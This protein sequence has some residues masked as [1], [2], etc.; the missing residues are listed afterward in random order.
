MLRDRGND[1]TPKAIDH[2]CRIGR[3]SRIASASKPNWDMVRTCQR[4][5]SLVSVPHV[6]APHLAAERR[7]TR[8][9]LPLSNQNEYT[10]LRVSSESSFF[11]PAGGGGVSSQKASIGVKQ[12]TVENQ[13][14][15]FHSM[16][17]RGGNITG[18]LNDRVDALGHYA[19]SLRSPKKP[20]RY[21]LFKRASIAI[22]DLRTG[23]ESV[24]NI[25]RYLRHGDFL[26]W[27]P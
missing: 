18:I 6:A 16:D 5:G 3:R 11:R 19:A 14:S 20:A 22:N 2:R 9:L 26:L 23:Y 8:S 21:D 4:I 10:R 25:G 1:R 13:C 7:A 15:Q 17:V 24:T 12:Q 27:A